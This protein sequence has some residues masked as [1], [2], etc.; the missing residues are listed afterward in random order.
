MDGWMDSSL[1]IVGVKST[2][3]ELIQYLDRLRDGFEC[4]N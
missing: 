4:N 1:M 3:T 2:D